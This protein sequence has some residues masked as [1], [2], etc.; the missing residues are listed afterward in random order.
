VSF[1]AQLPDLRALTP[2]LAVLTAMITPA[3]LMLACAGLI[4]STSTRLGRVVDRVRA[5]SDRFEELVRGE[6]RPILFDERRMLILDQL[7]KLTARAR[8]LQ[9]SMTTFYVAF[10]IFV[11]TSVAIGLLTVVSTKARYVPYVPVVVAMSGMGFLLAGA[12]L[13]ILEARLALYAV[14][15]EM[16]FVTRLGVQL[17]PAD[18]RRRRAR[19]GAPVVRPSDVDE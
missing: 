12:V 5:L 17:A 15:Q 18:V 14:H 13:L 9:F 1:G 3:V 7:D 6:E 19:T 16:E 10:A 11:G 2:A 8:L 4:G